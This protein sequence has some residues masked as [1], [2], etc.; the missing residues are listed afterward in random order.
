MISFLFT[1]LLIPGHGQQV[2]VPGGQPVEQP[3]SEQLSVRQI[4]V[5]VGQPSGNQPTNDRGRCQ[6]RSDVNPGNYYYDSC[7]QRCECTESG[8]SYAFK[9]FRERENYEC[10]S[11]ERRQRFHQ[12]ILDVSNPADPLYGTMKAFIERHGTGFSTVHIDQYFLHFHRAYAYELEEI[13]RQ[14]NCKITIPYWSF[15]D[16]PT[17]PFPYLPFTNQGMGD[18]GS[19]ICVATGPFAFWT[20]A[21]KT[22]CLSRNFV[23]SVLPTLTQLNQIMARGGLQFTLFANEMQYSYHNGVHVTIGADSV[24]PLSPNDP[25]FFLLHNNIDRQWWNWQQLSSDRMNTYP[26]PDNFIP[27]TR[28]VAGTVRPS[29]VN[30]LESTGVRY[31][32]VLGTDIKNNILPVCGYS[33][34][35]EGCYLRSKIEKYFLN[36]SLDILA[37][38]RQNR[39]QTLSKSQQKS[40]VQMMSKDKKSRQFIRKSL[41]QSAAQTDDL[42]NQLT[43]IVDEHLDSGFDVE[44]FVN[45]IGLNP[46]TQPYQGVCGTVPVSPTPQYVP[47]TSMYVNPTMPRYVPPSPRYESPS[48]RYESPSPRYESPSPRYESPSP[49]YESPSPR[50]VPPSPK[51]ES[52][53]PRYVPPSPRYVPPSPKYESPSPKYESPSPRYVPPSPRYE[54]PSPRYT[55]STWYEPSPTPAY[56]QP[57]TPIYTNPTPELTYVPPT[58]QYGDRPTPMTYVSPTNNVYELPP[59]RQYELSP[60]MRQYPILSVLDRHDL[61]TVVPVNNNRDVSLLLNRNQRSE[62]TNLING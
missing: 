13:L 33:K 45:T 37:D 14:K 12:A 47:P 39:P 2:R 62:L 56:N 36:T 49:R 44:A 55:P 40:W 1:L 24:T 25:L 61:E 15:S 41:Q 60:T 27:Y 8:R 23:N 28:T 7:E 5:P 6:E 58:N 32:Q 59:S 9:C 11:P 54:S 19:P 46:D 38:I 20:P 22:T 21:A 52:P 31:V 10:M 43:Q 42:C 57:T 4:R 29:E 30:S 18:N 3:F 50:Y 35:S 48:P 53:S 16:R 34:C 26:Y 51:Y 17:D